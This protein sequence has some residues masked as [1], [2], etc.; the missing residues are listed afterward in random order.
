[1]E[2]ST[3]KMNETNNEI[4]KWTKD[5]DI[6]TYTHKKDTYGISYNSIFSVQTSIGIV[7][8]L[9]TSNTHYYLFAVRHRRRAHRKLRVHSTYKYAVSCFIYKHIVWQ[10]RDYPSLSPFYMPSIASFIRNVCFQSF[11]VFP[12]HSPWAINQISKF[13]LWYVGT[14]RKPRCVEVKKKNSS[15]LGSIHKNPNDQTFFNLRSAHMFWFFN[16]EL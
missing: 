12:F 9:K 2:N 5:G 14:F 8:S 7:D 15:L 16:V 1:M 13:L 10:S 4:Q 11:I 6:Q 3:M